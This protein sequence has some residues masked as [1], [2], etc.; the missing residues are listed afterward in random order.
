MAVRSVATTDTLEKLRTEFN[1]LA[2]TDIGDAATL[3]TSASSIVGAINEVN[4]SIG[5]DLAVNTFGHL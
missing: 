1:S 2:A 4:T 3:S 5:G